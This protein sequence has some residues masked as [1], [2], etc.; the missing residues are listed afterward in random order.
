M[1]RSTILADW[2]T[3]MFGDSIEF[4][5]PEDWYRRGQDH[6]SKYKDANGFWRIRTKPGTFVWTPPPAAAD[7]A[8]EELRKA[9]LKRQSST[10]IIIIPRFMTIL[11]LIQL[12]KVVDLI[13]YLP[14]KYNFWP[15]AMHEPLVVAFCFPFVNYRPWQLKGTPNMCAFVRELHKLS[16][17][18]DLDPWEYFVPILQTL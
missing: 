10:H 17:E 6:I 7:A 5:A 8:L 9:R 15:H 12:N 4:L 11:W 13:V 3:T 2:I 1:E 16:K 18:T 14:N